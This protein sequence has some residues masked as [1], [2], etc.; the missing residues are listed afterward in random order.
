MVLPFDGRFT[1]VQRTLFPDLEKRLDIGIYQKKYISRPSFGSVGGCVMFK[2]KSFI[3][4]GMECEYM[5]SYGPED[6]DRWERFNRL[7]YNCKRIKGQLYHIEHWRGPDSC[8]K[9]PYFKANHDELE[10]MRLMTDQELREYVNTWEW[11]HP[12]SAEYYKE[13]SEGSARSAKIIFDSFGIK[14]KSVLDV[15]CGV[16]AWVQ[17]NIKWTG[18][19]Y[20]IPI[21]ALYEGVEFIECDLSKDF[22]KVGTFD[23]TI[24]M[25]VAEHLP[26]ERAK[27]LVKF[28]CSTS[29]TVLFS[30]AI[31]YQGGNGH[32]NEQWQTWWEEIFNEF[33]FYGANMTAIQNDEYVE[34]WYRQNTVLYT[35]GKFNCEG[36]FVVDYV[37][38]DYYEEKMK[39][40]N[41][42]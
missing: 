9:N 12:Y 38:P 10:K 8:N 27:D 11:V 16:G 21:D 31:P 39:N 1:G 6:V 13:I 5:I 22:P 4:G 37:L 3:S 33:G 36:E 30:A 19:D 20:N 34:F 17:P 35:R 23:L 14:P 2:K 41:K 25:E 40:K 15:G 26:I 28:L 29:N 32:I 24:C 18:I 42:L 7:G